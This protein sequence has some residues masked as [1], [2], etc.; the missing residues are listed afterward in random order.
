MYPPKLKS[1]YVT[2]LAAALVFAIT[3]GA[4]ESCAATRTA[5]LNVSVR[6]L[7]YLQL[8]PISQV[9]EI[10]ITEGD[11]KRGYLEVRSGS[12][13]EVKTNST[14]GYML[15]FDGSLWPFKEV[16][17][18]GLANTVQLNSGRV[19]VYQ[20][21]I[22]GKWTVDLSYRFIFTENTQPGSYSWP[23]SISILPI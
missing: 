13:L 21:S 20:P 17:I 16:Q 19:V 6:V 23:L 8:R 12:R 9:S 15:T 14:V 18:Q 2:V 7:P 11:I 5:S 3:L 10:T 1:G 22:K 4:Q